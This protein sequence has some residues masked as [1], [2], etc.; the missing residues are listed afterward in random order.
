M[1]FLHSSYLATRYY[2]IAILLWDEYLLI[3]VI[4]ISKCWLKTDIPFYV[5]RTVLVLVLFMHNKDQNIILTNKMWFVCQPYTWTWIMISF[6]CVFGNQIWW[7]FDGYQPYFT[8][9]VSNW[10]CYM[11]SH[12]MSNTSLNLTRIFAWESYSIIRYSMQGSNFMGPSWWKAS[13][14]LLF[15]MIDQAHHSGT[16]ENY[17]CKRCWDNGQINSELTFISLLNFISSIDC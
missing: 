4:L 16:L 2:W 7:Y 17:K 6:Q 10:Y 1:S 13:F 15:F 3:D 9:Q 5:A 8:F 12:I 14:L 11:D